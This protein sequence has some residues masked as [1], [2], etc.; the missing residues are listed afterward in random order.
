LQGLAAFFS[1]IISGKKASKEQISP[2]TPPFP[3]GLITIKPNLP[4]LKV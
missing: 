4:T 3:Y 2:K 1:V